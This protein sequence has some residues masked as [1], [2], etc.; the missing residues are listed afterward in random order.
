MVLPWSY[1]G[2][3]NSHIYIYQSTLQADIN[4]Q[5]RSKPKC[6]EAKAGI[7]KAHTG[8]QAGNI[9][10]YAMDQS[11]LADVKVCVFTFYTKES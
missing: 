5:C 11:S 4:K 1:Q 6:D 8:V 2:K 9:E 10:T 3:S 7:L